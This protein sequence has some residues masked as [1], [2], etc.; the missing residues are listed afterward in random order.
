MTRGGNR[1]IAAHPYVL[2]VL[3]APWT[4]AHRKWS[5]GARANLR[6]ALDYQARL[7]LA[8]TRLIGAQYPILFFPVVDAR[9]G[10]YHWPNSLRPRGLRNDKQGTAGHGLW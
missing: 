8:W 6:A 2:V 10:A 1:S 7:S 3:E 4:G 9:T 5:I